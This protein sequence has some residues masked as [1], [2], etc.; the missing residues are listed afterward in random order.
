MDNPNELAKFQFK[1]NQVRTID[2]DGEVWFVAKDVC[3]VLGLTNTSKAADSLDTDEKGI[4]NG[5]TLGGSQKMIIVSE[6]GVYKLI[7]KSRKKVAK[8]FTKWVTSEVLPTIRRTGGY[9]KTNPEDTPESIMA[10][11][12]LIAKD[13]IDRQQALINEANNRI[14]ELAPDAE[15]A[16]IV[17]SAG[18]LHTINEIAVHVGISAIKMNKFLES[19]GW[20]Y[21]QGNN[22]LPA[23]KIRGRELCDFHIVPYAYD[24]DG[25]VK[26]RA[27]LKWTEKGR[28]AII[29][30][31]QFK[32]PVNQPEKKQYYQ[33]ITLL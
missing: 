9:I 13:T 30:L 24:S 2:K 12:L 4:T 27:H 32:N 15:Y 1:N 5:D 26:T 10:R 18:N 17:L 28:K 22:I 19:K 21:R 14:K 7:F 3:D 20:I 8:E 11:G 6:S 29:D 23:I 31:W 16:Q 25:N 33:Q